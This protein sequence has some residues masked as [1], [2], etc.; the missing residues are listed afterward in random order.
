MKFIY[1]IAF[2][3]SLLVLNGCKKPDDQG[4]EEM[5]KVMSEWKDAKKVA[6]ASPRMSLSGQI[7]NLQSIKTKLSS[8]ET[9]DCLKE[10]KQHLI[11]H[12]ELEIDIFVSFLGKSHIADYRFTD[13]KEPLGKYTE[14]ASK[15]SKK[16][17]P[18]P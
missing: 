4:L 17:V 6:E 8:L 10:A 14:A 11:R 15:C 13:A 7:S 12:M 2:V 16:A 18:K 3:M 9:S 5:Q 1:I